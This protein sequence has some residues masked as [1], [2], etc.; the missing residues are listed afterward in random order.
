MTDIER[1]RELCKSKGVPVSALEKALGF[2]NG[3]LNPKKAKTI[4]YTRLMQIAAYFNVPISDLMIGT[5]VSG[6]KELLGH[7][8][9]DVTREIYT[10]L[11]QKQK[12][13]SLANLRLG[14]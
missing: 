8:D 9:I 1:V 2:S 10:H 3:Y 11:R 14:I 12:D 7:S 13:K 4:S 5:G 6:E